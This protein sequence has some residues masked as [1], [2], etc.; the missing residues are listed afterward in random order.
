MNM[1]RF[2]YST[3]ALLPWLPAAALA[4]GTEDF[5]Y[6]RVVRILFGL[7]NFLM[8][9]GLV[10]AV[11]AIVWFG[12]QI[13]TSGGNATRY[14]EAKKSIIWAVVGAAI[15]LGINTILATIEAVITNQSIAG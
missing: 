8:N 11:I 14:Q 2:W 5:T 15:I 1:K 4:Q 9:I 7:A 12:I 10:I 6:D 3:I 13:M